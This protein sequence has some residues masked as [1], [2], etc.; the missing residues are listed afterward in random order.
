M[1]RDFLNE[2]L[3]QKL[4]YTTAKKEK[5]DNFGWEFTLFWKQHLYKF[6]KMQTS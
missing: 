5:A 4:L 3:R 1:N 6:L 2:K